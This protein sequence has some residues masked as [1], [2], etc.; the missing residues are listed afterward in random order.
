MTCL[1]FNSIQWRQGLLPKITRIWNSGNLAIWQLRTVGIG[2]DENFKWS[3][4]HKISPNDVIEPYIMHFFMHGQ[5]ARWPNSISSQRH[6]FHSHNLPSS[7]NHNIKTN[8]LKF[9]NWSKPDSNQT[10]VRMM[11][12]KFRRMSLRI[13][14]K[15]RMH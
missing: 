7:T 2:F 12:L 13:M 3:L 4:F 5:V 11:I 9:H 6:I 15:L 8:F 14:L 1:K 10:L